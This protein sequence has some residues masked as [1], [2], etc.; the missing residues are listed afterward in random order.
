M[1]TSGAISKQGVLG[2]G[3]I[4]LEKPFTADQLA[5]T[6]RLALDRRGVSGAHRTWPAA[7]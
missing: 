3:A 5:R 2:D 7:G 1:L 6:I 4:L